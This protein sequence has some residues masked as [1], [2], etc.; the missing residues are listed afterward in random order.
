MGEQQI[1]RTGITSITQNWK[2]PMYHP[3]KSDGME[4]FFIAQVI[5][6]YD[7]GF[8]ASPCQWGSQQKNWWI[9]HGKSQDRNNGT[10]IYHTRIIINSQYIYTYIYIFRRGVSCDISL[11][12][13]SC[14]Y[15]LNVIACGS[16]GGTVRLPGRRDRHPSMEVQHWH[17]V[18]CVLFRWKSILCWC[19]SYFKFIC[20][21]IFGVQ[22]IFS[23]MCCSFFPSSTAIFASTFPFFIGVFLPS[24][25][26]KGGRDRL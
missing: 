19:L 25:S 13:F 10:H 5:G 22:P 6:C 24:K 1:L 12:I 21:Y 20:S 23:H 7:V 14:D 3:E 9:Y 18:S 17:H 2:I 11:D 16:W 26:A 8:N 15:V 4:V